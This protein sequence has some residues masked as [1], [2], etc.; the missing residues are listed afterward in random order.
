MAN[1]GERNCARIR[2]VLKKGNSR[3][4]RGKRLPKG[5]IRLNK[6]IEVTQRGEP[7]FSPGKGQYITLENMFFFAVG[8]AMVIAIYT[9][10]S[11]ISDS[12]RS[13]ALEDQL[14][15][16]GENIRSAMVK[17]FMAGNS[18][19]SVIRFSLEIPK[20]LSGCSYKITAD[21][22]S[23]YMSC[24]DE[25]TS[26]KALNL[27]GIET[28]IKNGAAYSSSGKIDIFYSGGNIMIS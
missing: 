26:A 14:E 5:G 28:T 20:Q 19:G 18:T 2:I 10:F 22:N 9:A 12:M 23:L 25:A 8:I 16:E 7:G 15:K 4:T 24:I 21:A 13:A 27:Y 11:S 3:S 1:K 6:R 17:T